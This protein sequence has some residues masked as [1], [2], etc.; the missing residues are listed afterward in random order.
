[1]SAGPARRGR[2]L[3]LQHRDFVRI[4]VK[5]GSIDIVVTKAHDAEVGQVVLVGSSHNPITGL[6]KVGLFL[7]SL[8]GG[9]LGS[10]FDSLGNLLTSVGIL[11]GIFL[12]I[13]LLLGVFSLW[14]RGHNYLFIVDGFHLQSHLRRWWTSL[15]DCIDR[16]VLCSAGLVFCL[17]RRFESRRGALFRDLGFCLE[18]AQGLA[19][20]TKRRHVS[21]RLG[22]LLCDGHL[23]HAFRKRG[24]Q[25]LGLLHLVGCCLA[26]FVSSLGGKLRLSLR[27]F[28]FGVCL[29]VTFDSLL[30]GLKRPF[31]LL[32]LRFHDLFVGLP[33][34]L[35]NLLQR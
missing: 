18:L 5:A 23:G 21:L 26:C 2:L 16:F 7:A 35:C 3:R 27:D 22:L 24:L 8:F 17:V 11:L 30:L 10:L 33:L 28:R 25:L 34:F 14:R 12:S 13:L 32:F 9:L 15:V 1:M 6:T 20:G 19:S 4:W 29:D 31:G